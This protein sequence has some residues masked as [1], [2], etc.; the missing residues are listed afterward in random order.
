MLA[1]LDEVAIEGAYRRGVPGFDRAGPVLASELDAS[2][3]QRLVDAITTR[4][5]DYVGQE[6][7]RLSTMPVWEQGQLTPRPF[8]PVSYTHL[9]LPTNR[10]V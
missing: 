2:D 5:M 8:V 10:E 3:R 6:V 9:T 4:G 1:R 7:V